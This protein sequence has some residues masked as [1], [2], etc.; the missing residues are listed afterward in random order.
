MQKG[1][2]RVLS[3]LLLCV[4][5]LAIPYYVS[6]ANNEL[7]G[8]VL[9]SPG[10]TISYDI[11]INTTD[12]VN[13]YVTTLTYDTVALELVGID[14]QNS[15]TGT[16]TIG[17]SPLDLTFNHSSGLT[18]ENVIAKIKFRVKKDS[19][20]SS[21]T[22]NLSAPSITTILDVDGLLSYPIKS[23]EKASKTVAIKSS[24]NSL[25]DLKVNN[26]TVNNFKK[27]AYEYVM[28]VESSVSQVAVTA[29]LSNANATFVKDFGPRTVDVNY[30][31]NE[32]VVK[33]KSE[34][35]E[36]KV[37]TIRITRV[38]DRETNNYLK[39]III[40]AGKVK[41]NFN[42]L[43]LD[44]E[45]TTYKLETLE[46]EVETEDSKAKTTVVVPEEV[47]YGNNIVTVTVL[48]E[49]G[50]EKVYTIKINNIDKEMDTSLK[51]LTIE[52]YD[53]EFSKDIL[54]YQIRYNPK[55]KN[56]LE[57][58]YS[59]TAL[60][61]DGVKIDETLVQKTNKNLVP[62]SVIQIRVFTP[63]GVETMYTITILE[64]TRLNF[65]LILGIFILVILIVALLV[66]LKKIK[67]NK[68][69]DVGIEIVKE[70]DLQKTKEMVLNRSGDKE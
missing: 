12:T 66:L 51:T 11:K 49:S 44:Y 60:E 50:E 59:Q 13:K 32:V 45:I 41:I 24:D 1:L 10:D 42:K 43:V 69:V 61:K 16:N 6:A 62:G 38:D 3:L 53:I 67:K 36:E 22:I 17:N 54:E 5:S 52:G 37:Y 4:I 26:K 46:V 40:N 39:S 15:W 9:A 20:K 7:D 56:G 27:D 19:G 47:V 25:S 63:D 31:E 23:L 28:Q 35:G 33:T 18:G 48:A 34:S 65:F 57:I 64:D 29:T 55:Y 68:A 58:Y 21:A 70:E 14:N 8:V 30:G 2:K